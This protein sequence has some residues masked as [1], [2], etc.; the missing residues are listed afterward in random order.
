MH[1]GVT[2]SRGRPTPSHLPP[3]ARVRCNCRCR[4][5]WSRR[6]CCSGR[7]A[8]AWAAPA[9]AQRWRR[10]RR[11]PSLL[12]QETR[13]SSTRLA[14]STHF[15]CRRRPPQAAVCFPCRR[16]SWAAAPRWLSLAR[17][18]VLARSPGDRGDYHR[19]DTN[20][21]SQICLSAGDL[22]IDLCTALLCLLPGNSL[23]ETSGRNSRLPPCCR[24]GWS[25]STTSW[26]A[27]I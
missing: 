4:P 23:P 14:Q 1:R 12:Q 8:A 11:Q 5:S 10:L 2:A 19:S 20:A 17:H 3:C 16:I 22:L 7:G 25:V 6:L 27:T 18:A 13:S 21:D 15:R 9:S 26:R 24:C